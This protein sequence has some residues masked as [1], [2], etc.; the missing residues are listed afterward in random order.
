MGEIIILAT[1]QSP[2][3]LKQTELAIQ[4]LQKKLPETTFEVL[5]LLTTGDRQ[6]A[7]SLEEQ[8]G[9]GLFTK[10][11]EDALLQGHAHLAVHSTKDLPTELPAGLVLAGFLPREDSRDVLVTRQGLLREEI[12]TLASGSPRRRAQAKLLLPGIQEL[13][14]I[15]GRVTTRLDK[16]ADGY[17]DATIVAAAGLKRLGISEAYPGVDLSFLEVEE[18]V[19][20]VG[21][22]VIGLEVSEGLL[23]RFEGLFDLD[24]GY[25]VRVE[26]TFLTAL[27]GGCHAAYAGH[28]KNG[29]LHIYHEKSGYKKLPFLAQGKGI[30]EEIEKIVKAL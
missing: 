19:P 14:E 12:R 30:Q 29:Y 22:G 7:W 23:E 10:E 26:R 28:Y 18:M 4:Y 8:G 11:L 6:A 5:P 9:K 24:A 17:A 16:I 27:G 21:Q 20:A 15:R 13:K 2:L 1:R 25:A 3:A